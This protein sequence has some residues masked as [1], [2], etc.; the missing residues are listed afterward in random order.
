MLKRHSFSI[1]SLW[2][3]TFSLPILF[4]LMLS[5]AAQ[6][7]FPQVL[8]TEW[9]FSNWKGLLINESGLLRSFGISILISVVVA[10]VSTSLG[11]WM[12]R[13][14]AFHPKKNLFVSLTYLPFVFSPV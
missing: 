3:I 9:T 8:P 5:L 6:W 4:L 11:F 14:I 12:S 1:A 2:A 10:L 13:A 7:R